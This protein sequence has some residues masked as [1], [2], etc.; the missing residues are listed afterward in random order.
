MFY[1]YEKKNNTEKKFKK[2]EVLLVAFYR[3]EK[4]KT[5]TDPPYFDLQKHHFC[6]VQP[7]T[8]VI[9][10]VERTGTSLVTAQ[11]NSG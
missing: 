6:R 11:Q 5:N 3:Y 4:K 8:L 7:N 2:K 1:R 9:N 10:Y